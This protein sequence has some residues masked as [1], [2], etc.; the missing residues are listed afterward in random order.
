[1]RYIW[2]VRGINAGGAG[3]WSETLT[4]ST[5]EPD[6]SVELPVTV[7]LDQN[8]PNPFNPRTTIP[9]DLGVAGEVTLTIFDTLGRRVTTLI[10]GTLSAGHHEVGWDA[11]RLPSGIYL[12]RLQTNGI[13]K[14]RSLSLLR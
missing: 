5:K 13:V 8:Y 4:Y 7:A 6:N 9:F 1:M 11:S 2:R 10:D 14:S 3:V 12:Y